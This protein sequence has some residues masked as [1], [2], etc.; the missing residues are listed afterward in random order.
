MTTHRK[1]FTT[2]LGGFAASLL[3]ALPVFGASTYTVRRGDCAWKIAQR[4]GVS[5]AELLKANHLSKRSLLQP[6]QR[7][8]VPDRPVGRGRPPAGQA[9]SPNRGAGS[10]PATTY[11]VRKGDTLGAIAHRFGVSVK[12]LARGNGIRNPNRLRAGRTLRLR[13]DVEQA[14]TLRTGPRSEDADQRPNSGNKFVDTA[15]RYRGVPYRYAGMTTRGM[16]CSG[17][18][19]RVLITHGIKAPHS[20][21]ELY[22]LGRAVPRDQLQSGDLVFFRTRGRG[23]SHVGIYMGDGKFIHASSSGG[24]VEVDRLDVGYYQRRYVG[25]RRVT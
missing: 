11:V 13:G 5:T 1:V 21:R 19:A 20:S 10:Q 16:D 12:A 2:L 23:I 18:V 25:A 17:L 8:V 3:I 22:Q 9:A 24:K 14:L 6:G 15:L 7:L 4:L